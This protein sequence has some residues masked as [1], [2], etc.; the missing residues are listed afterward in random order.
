MKRSNE[1]DNKEKLFQE[2]E[3]VNVLGNLESFIYLILAEK[4]KKT[5]LFRHFSEFLNIFNTICLY[6]VFSF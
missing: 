4:I 5:I 1:Y 6:Y 2:N 3:K